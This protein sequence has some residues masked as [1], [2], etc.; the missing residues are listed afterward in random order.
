MPILRDG[1]GPAD[2]VMAWVSVPDLGVHRLDQ[3]YEPLD[4]GR[5]RYSDEDFVRD[6]SVGPDG[7]VTHYPDLG[8]L[9]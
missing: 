1:G 8:E 3:R 4:D 7:F 5:I 6:L 2:Y 9:V